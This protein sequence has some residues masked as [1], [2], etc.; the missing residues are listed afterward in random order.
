MASTDC[1]HLRRAVGQEL[2]E[3]GCVPESWA[4]RSRV[5][6]HRWSSRVCGCGP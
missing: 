4:T 3:E 6:D 5:P 2:A 1:L